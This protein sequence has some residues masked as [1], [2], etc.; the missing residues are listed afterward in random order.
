MKV[1]SIHIK[2]YRSFGEEGRIEFDSNILALIGRNGVGKT[3]A[4]EVISRLCFFN[5]GVPGIIPANAVNQNT[6]KSPE[7]VITAQLDDADIVDLGNEIAGCIEDR[8]VRYIFKYDSGSRQT[9]LSFEGAFLAVMQKCPSLVALRPGI[10]ELLKLMLKQ[11]RD[12]DHGYRACVAALQ[13]YDKCFIPQFRSVLAWVKN[14]FLNYADPAL[15]GKLSPVVDTVVS[16]VGKVYEAFA[17]I[18]PVVHMFADAAEFPDVYPW[19]RINSWDQHNGLDWNSRIALERFLGAVG[20]SRRELSQAFT[21]KNTSL[22]NNIQDRIAKTTRRLMRE[23]NDSYMKGSAEI[24]LN[25]KFE[26]NALRFTVGSSDTSGSVQWSE[27]S[28][29]VRWYLSAFFSLR[30]AIK[31]RSAII[32]VDEPAIHLHVKAQKEVLALLQGLAAD[33]KYLIYTTHSQFMIDKERLG[34]VRAIVKNGDVSEIRKLTG[35]KDVASRMEVLTPVYHALGYEL[36]AGL[37]PNES[38]L[39]LIVEGITDHHYINAMFAALGI[40]EEKRPNIIP[41][42]GASTVGNM[43]SICIGWG[44]NF[45]VLLDSDDAGQKAR[46]KLVESFGEDLP[47]CMLSEE[48]ELVIENLVAQTDFQLVRG[49]NVKPEAF[50]ETK[51][52]TARKFAAMVYDK[53]LKVSEETKN[54]FKNLFTLLKIPS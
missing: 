43:V 31:A 36:A 30:K 28:A 7:V 32:L 20:S 3:N 10:D 9:V 2:N 4:L 37:G 6:G 26:G 18:S 14:N 51:A 22:R 27:T 38:K 47:L 17:H 44:L 24:E 13:N 8:V 45:K 33:S 5:D 11:P 25:V 16:E 19:E 39:N 40:P 48:K 21:E 1:N 53:S 12:N 41:C 34:D 52:E 42:Q 29:G 15:K 49:D 50:G 54:N 35:I 23:F 46:K